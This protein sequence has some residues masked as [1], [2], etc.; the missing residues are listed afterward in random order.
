MLGIQE[1]RWA[2]PAQFRA[3]HFHVIAAAKDAANTA[4]CQ[5]WIN[6]SLPLDGPNG[7]ATIKPTHIQPRVVQHRI[8]AATVKSQAL[9]ATFVALHA[10]S[11]SGKHSHAE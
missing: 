11:L 5:L 8:V 3:D 1:G 2:S 4:G 6:T 9:F 10:P 7:R